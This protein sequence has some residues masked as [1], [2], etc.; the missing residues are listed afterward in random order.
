MLLRNLKLGW[1]QVFYLHIYT[2][3]INIYEYWSIHCSESYCNCDIKNGQT[4]DW[5]ASDINLDIVIVIDTSA[6]MSSRLQ[7]VVYFMFFLVLLLFWKINNINI[8]NIQ[9]KDMVTSFIRDMTTDPHTEYHSNIGVIAGSDTAEV[10]QNLLL[11]WKTFNSRWCIIWT[12][13]PLTISIQSN[14]RTPSLWISMSMGSFSFHSRC[15]R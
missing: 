1:H 2:F 6:S 4:V 11:L 7:E 15:Q 13:A 8:N 3:V 12:W 10:I 9:A 14:R 5:K